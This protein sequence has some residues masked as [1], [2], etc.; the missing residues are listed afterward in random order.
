M[1]GEQAARPQR[2]GW[3]AGCALGVMGN[4]GGLF[5][6]QWSDLIHEVKST[7][8]LQMESE[9]VGAGTWAETQRKEAGGR[10]GLPSRPEGPKRGQGGDGADLG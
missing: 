3:A 6:W 9:V 10:L 4:P 8:I 1:D 2:P 5:S 7:C